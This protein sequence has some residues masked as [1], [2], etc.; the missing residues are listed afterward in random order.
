MPRAE[1]ARGWEWMAAYVKLREL[2]R[3][4]I[5]VGIRE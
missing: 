4:A 3:A 5:G 2:V 1:L